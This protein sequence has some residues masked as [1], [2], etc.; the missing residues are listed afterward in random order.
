MSCG[1]TVANQSCDLSGRVEQPKEKAE[2]LSSAFWIRFYFAR[3]S[4]KTQTQD[5]SEESLSG[6]GTAAAARFHSVRIVKSETLLFDAVIPIERGA[7]QVKSTLLIY[8]DGNA[9][10][11]VFAVG[12]FVEAIV[13]V[14][15]VVE[16]AATAA[17]YADT[18]KLVV[19]ELVFFSE[20]LDL[21]GCILGEHDCHG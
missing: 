9:V 5:Q 13:E 2:L 4:P 8:H 14:Q 3:V 7:V 6:E 10:I 19:C 1:T 15:R 12:S 16:S 17:S 20:L 11:L 18:Q 21:I